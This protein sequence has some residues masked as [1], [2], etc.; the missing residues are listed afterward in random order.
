MV[1]YNELQN[2][3]D[4]DDIQMRWGELIAYLGGRQKDLIL[5]K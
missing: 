5:Q 4:N 1:F 2:E 3:L